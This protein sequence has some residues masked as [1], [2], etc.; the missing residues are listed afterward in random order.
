QVISSG[1]ND[2]R[3]ARLD[4]IELPYAPTGVIAE[5]NPNLPKSVKVSWSPTFDGNSPLI[6]FIVQKRRAPTDGAIDDLGLNWETVLTNVSAASAS[7]IVSELRA[8]TAYQFRVSAV[9]NVGEGSPSLPSNTLIL[10]QEAP[11]GPPQGLVG[12]PRSPT[13]IMIQWEAPPEEER[14]GQIHG[15]MV[16]YR[17]WGYKDSQWYYRNITKE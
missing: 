3:S 11:S 16:R 9:N 1:G 5:K 12:S 13:E 17:L 14:N 6:K 8:S 4:V 7:A 15:Y 10:P 2:T